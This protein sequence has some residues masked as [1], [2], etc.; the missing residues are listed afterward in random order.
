MQQSDFGP[1]SAATDHSGAL[2]LFESASIGDVLGT[3]S[4]ALV[5]Y[6][7][8]LAA[9]ANLLLSG[10][11]VPWQHLIGAFDAGTGAALPAFPAVTDD[12]QF[13]SSSTVAKLVPTATSNQVVAGSGLGLLHAYDG[14]TGRDVAGFPK[15]TGG[16]LYAPATLSHDGR[17]TDI[18]REGFLFQWSTHAPACQ[19]EWPGFRHDQQHSGNYDRDGTPPGAPSGLRVTGNKLRFAAPGDDGPCGTVAGHFEVAVADVPITART[20]AAARPVTSGVPQPQAP[21]TVESV[22]LPAGRY[23]AVRAVDDAGNVGPLSALQR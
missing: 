17:L 2:N 20:F 19:S 6:Q 22:V 12:Y 9:A 3:G 16:W 7:T 10:Q 11:N 8:T 13:L 4:P 21:G 5:K 14:A 23:V 18:T 1:A 15:Q